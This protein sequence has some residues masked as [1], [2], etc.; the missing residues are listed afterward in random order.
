MMVVPGPL[1]SMWWPF[2]FTLGLINEVTGR[3]PSLNS[4]I[5][6]RLNELAV[7][8]QRGMTV[9]MQWVSGSPG[10]RYDSPVT[11]LR[12]AYWAHRQ[13]HSLFF[14]NGC[15][16]SL[17]G[18]FSHS[19]SLS[20]SLF[21]CHSLP[22]LLSLTLSLYCSLFLSLSLI[23]SQACSLSLSRSLSLSLSLSLILS[24]TQR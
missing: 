12:G 19:L 17:L 1:C 5:I 8:D 6:R 15:S 14:H 23:L 10:P 20:L 21:L 11:S 18:S 22:G 24:L 4:T 7:G 9:Q 3:W 2:V 13:R 16:H